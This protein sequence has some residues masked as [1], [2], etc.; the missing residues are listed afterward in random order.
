MSRCLYSFTLKERL[1]EFFTQ[2]GLSKV[3]NFYKL[4]KNLVILYNKL[5]CNTTPLT[6]KNILKKQ[7]HNVGQ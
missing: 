3:K 4:D 6:K 7:Y 5:I 1:N 2:F